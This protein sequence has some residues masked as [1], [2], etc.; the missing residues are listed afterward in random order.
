MLTRQTAIK[1]VLISEDD[2]QARVRTLGRQISADYAH[3]KEPL[4]LISILSGSFVFTADLMRYI[5]IPV[6]IHFMSVSSYGSG[7]QS[8]GVVKIE[9]DLSINITN[10]HVVIV[11]DIVDTGL[12]LHYLRDFLADRNPQSLSICTLLDKHEARQKQVDLRY[13][14][15]PIPEEFVVGY[16]LDFNHLFREL[17]YIA[18][19]KPEA[20]QS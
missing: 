7:T 14:G 11:E 12:T 5:T 17:S 15:F 1:E 18:V 13:I 6:E 20:Y 10:R 2:I 8:T 9:K 4:V 19:L 16:G 3:L